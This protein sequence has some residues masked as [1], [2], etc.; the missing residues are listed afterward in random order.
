M[1]WLMV[2]ITPIFIITL[3]TSLAFTAMRLASSPTVIV[4]ETFTSRFIGAVGSSKPWR[5]STLTCT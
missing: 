3:I 4:S 2:A 1:G 5:A